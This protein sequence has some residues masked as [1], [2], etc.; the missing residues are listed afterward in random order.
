MSKAD[1]LKSFLRILA[2]IGPIVLALNPV[3]A[4]YAD[5]ISIL[6]HEAEGAIDDPTDRRAHVVASAGEFGAIVNRK[7]GR[8]VV[9]VDALKDATGSG[10]D[11]TVKAVNLIRDM[12]DV[13]A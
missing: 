6:I 8:D 5:D 10:V 12:D 13:A 3:T 2:K 9:D 11:A 4:P 7:A 1:K